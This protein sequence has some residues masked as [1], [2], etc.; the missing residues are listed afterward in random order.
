MDRCELHLAPRNETMV[1]TGVFDVYR[2]IHHSRT[3]WVQDVVHP[4]YVCLGQFGEEK[5]LVP[6]INGTPWVTERSERCSTFRGIFQKLICRLPFGQCEFKSPF[7][8]D[9][10]LRTQHGVLQGLLYLVGDVS[11]FRQTVAFVCEERFSG[12]PA[13]QWQVHGQLAFSLVFDLYEDNSILL[14]L[15]QKNECQFFSFPNTLFVGTSGTCSRMLEREGERFG[16][17]SVPNQPCAA[18]RVSMCRPTIAH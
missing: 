15:N 8:G 10:F 4:Q 12:R 3:S 1:E 18:G 6:S 16:N 7:G 2:G 11:H 5:A 14:K 9:C 17:N 13:S